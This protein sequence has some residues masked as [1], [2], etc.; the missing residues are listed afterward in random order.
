LTGAFAALAARAA[1]TVPDHFASN[2]GM[3]YRALA[4]TTAGAAVKNSSRAG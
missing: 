1:A 3:P 2:Q 4:S